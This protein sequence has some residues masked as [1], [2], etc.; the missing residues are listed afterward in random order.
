MNRHLVLAGLILLCACKKHNPGTSGNNGNNSKVPLYFKDIRINETNVDGSVAPFQHAIGYFQLKSDPNTQIMVASR[1]TQELNDA[2]GFRIASVNKTTGTVN[3]VKSFDLPDSFMIQ[4]VTSATIDNSDNVWVAGHSFA[5]TGVAGILFLTEL[6]KTGNILW[7]GSLS[8]YQG[9]RAYSV[10][11]LQN[12]DVALF[13]KGIGGLSILRL[14]PGRQLVWSTMIQYN[15]TPIDDDFYGNNNNTLSPENHAMVETADGSIYVATT[16]NSGVTGAPGSDRLYRLDANG[17][18]QFAKVYTAAG[19]GVVHPVQLLNAGAG[20]LL[21]ADQAVTSGNV[22]AF[23]YFIKL[24]LDGSIVASRGVPVSMA[25]PAR[26]QIN[27]VISYQ[28]NFSLSTCGNL[29]FNTYILDPNLNLKTSIETI[30]AED[31]GTDRGGI[32]LFDTA[33]NSL[34][35]LCNFAGN[36]GESNGFEVTR[37]GP[38]GKPCIT[39]YVNP[40]DA[41]LLQDIQVTVI[42]DSAAKTVTAGPVP[43]FTPLNWQPH[44]VVV[45][46]TVV[47]CGQ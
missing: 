24:S 28:G 1:G 36:F 44:N 20:N 4:L 19:V 41:L 35:Y 3:W 8:N 22:F 38:D 25:S 45:A 18:L 31:I 27:E 47:V 2:R 10:L 29:Q 33:T 37:N 39:T 32:S 17:N 5:S 43:V 13:A 23:P 34:Y 30:A 6:D 11:V 21:M 40:P 46:S 26:D 15:N 9:L 14:S 7:S 12:G 42:A 16:S